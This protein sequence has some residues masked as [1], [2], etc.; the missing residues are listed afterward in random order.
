MIYLASPYSHPEPL[1]REHRFLA[2]CR[3]AAALMRAGAVV[4][5]PVAHS[6]PI[7]RHGLPGG[8]DFW[9][10]QDRPHLERCDAVVVLQL[11]G[12]VTSQGVLAELGLA[13]QLGKPIWFLDPEVLAAGSPT[14][15][16]VA[17]KGAG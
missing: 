13:R 6:H 9:E 1:V 3:A 8:W 15:A 4:Y 5:S 2:V 16:H 7:A 12:W 11:E 10:R 17:A 14:L